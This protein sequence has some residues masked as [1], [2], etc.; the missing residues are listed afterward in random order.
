MLVCA[1]KNKPQGFR[2]RLTSVKTGRPRSLASRLHAH[3]LRQQARRFDVAARRVVD[4]FAGSKSRLLGC[5]GGVRGTGVDG[6][7]F[8]L[9]IPLLFFLD[10]KSPC[11]KRIGCWSR[12][13]GFG[14]GW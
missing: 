11:M 5:P 13:P 14:G 7:C 8:Y 2:G 6:V 4:N 12:G 9:L 10:P 3:K 1:A